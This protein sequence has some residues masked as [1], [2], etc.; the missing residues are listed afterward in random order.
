MTNSNSP[1]SSYATD[2]IR[3]Q[4][5]AV[6][7]S[8]SP[9]AMPLIN[10]YWLVPTELISLSLIAKQRPS[11]LAEH[12]YLVVNKENSRLRY[13]CSQKFL[14]YCFTKRPDLIEGSTISR[15]SEGLGL[16]LANAINSI[17]KD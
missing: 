12:I 4:C 16:L 9:S 5:L 7:D 1:I 8:A 6:Y 17:R 2:D 10:F 13:A 15:P 14:A 3:Y 11:A